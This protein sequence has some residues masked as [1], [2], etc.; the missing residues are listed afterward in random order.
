MEG[1]HPIEFHQHYRDYKEV[2]AE[3]LE[4]LLREIVNKIQNDE[5]F[6][7]TTYSSATKIPQ[8]TLR[9][10]V[11]KKLAGPRYNPITSSHGN[12]ALLRRHDKR[13]DGCNQL[14]YRKLVPD[15]G[16]PSKQ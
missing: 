1:F 15:E 11:D 2:G 16:L 6:A 13:T 4:S 8:T 7:L 10:C 3:S 9:R 14:L 12:Q 5:H